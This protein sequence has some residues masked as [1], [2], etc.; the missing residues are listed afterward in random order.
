MRM[1][2]WKRSEKRFCDDFTPISVQF[3][4]L[5]LSV[6]V[7]ICDVKSTIVCTLEYI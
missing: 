2:L 3:Y 4:P 7:Y 5:Y 6:T 1:S